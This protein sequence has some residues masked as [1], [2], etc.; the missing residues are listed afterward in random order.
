MVAERS[1]EWAKIYYKG[2][3]EKECNYSGP[4]KFCGGILK[5]KICKYDI[6]VEGQKK[7]QKDSIEP[8]KLIFFS[9][10]ALVCITAELSDD[11]KI[12]GNVAIKSLNWFFWN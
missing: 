5:V 3:K 9:L 12:K 6:V 4:C 1:N 2:F 8:K 10:N 7:T 11:V